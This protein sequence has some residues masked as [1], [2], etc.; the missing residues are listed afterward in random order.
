M[1][2]ARPSF[3]FPSACQALCHAH[4][5]ISPPP[6]RRAAHSPPAFFFASHRSASLTYDH[7]SISEH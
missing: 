1:S 7:A 4:T 3:L 5:I 6:M 2:L